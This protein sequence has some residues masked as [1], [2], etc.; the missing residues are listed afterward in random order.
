LVRRPLFFFGKA[1][2]S[3]FE[4]FFDIRGRAPSLS[5][6]RFFS[7]HF[8]SSPSPPPP[9][10]PPLP[11]DRGRLFPREFLVVQW[12]GRSLPPSPFC[13]RGGFLLSLPFLPYLMRIEGA[14]FFFLVISS[15][16]SLRNSPFLCLKDESREIDPFFLLSPRKTS[17]FFRLVS[18]KGD[19]AFFLAAESSS[20]LDFLLFIE[21]RA[22]S[23]PLEISYFPCL[24]FFARS[25]RG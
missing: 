6:K 24:S 9:P 2:S 23:S 14:S 19:G 20:L 7:I 15:P 4:L 8:L 13:E 18:A 17:L 25:S 21:G 22:F 12:G 11:E 10:S 1:S 5:V 16:L 3:P